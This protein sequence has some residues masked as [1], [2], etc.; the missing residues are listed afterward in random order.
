MQLI[1]YQQFNFNVMVND[2]I[3]FKFD[4]ET[5][6]IIEAVEKKWNTYQR[7]DLIKLCK[8]LNT[9]LLRE[10]KGEI[11]ISESK[12]PKY[13]ESNK[14]RHRDEHIEIENKRRWPIPSWF[15]EYSKTPGV[16]SILPIDV[17]I[18]LAKGDDHFS[19]F[20]A[21][22]LSTIESAIVPEFMHYQFLHS[23]NRDT[24]E[25]RRAMQFI[26]ADFGSVIGARGS[27][28]EEILNIEYSSNTSNTETVETN[29][30]VELKSSVKV[31]Q[32]PQNDHSQVIA[33]NKQDAFTEIEIHLFK[34]NFINA[35][36]EWQKEKVKLVIF[37]QVLYRNKFFK[38]NCIK[39]NK[40]L[41][42]SVR[43]FFEK[44]YSQDIADAFKPSNLS[45]KLFNK[46]SLD[47]TFVEAVE[48]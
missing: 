13:F 3:N 8:S 15:L 44:R 27:V 31:L 41:G 7:V 21:Y 34:K 5:S 9:I 20:F 29:T 18:K 10:R 24:L 42:A 39:D 46:H 11:V 14:K 33:K 1:A 2:N 6:S 26:L 12:Q 45:P 30:V 47:F 32:S 4:I 36:Y 35:S 25:F 48:S 28:I 37:I 38:K 19:E 40:N 17:S 23:F 43:H 16:I 22:R